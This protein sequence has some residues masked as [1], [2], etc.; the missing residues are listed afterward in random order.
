MRIDL[1][2]CNLKSCR[3]CSDANCRDKNRYSSCDYARLKDA[4]YGMWEPIVNA[5]GELVEFICDC[6][7]SQTAAHNYCPNC[8]KKMDNSNIEQRIKIA[9][10][11][12]LN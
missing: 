10:N 7:C 12:E 6:G 1:P 9:I 5:L 8:G 11:N 2:S 4:E 3:Y